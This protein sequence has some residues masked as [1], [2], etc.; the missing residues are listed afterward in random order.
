MQEAGQEGYAVRGWY[1][2]LL[3]AGVPG[4]I[5]QKLNQAARLALREP[6]VAARLASFGSPYVAGS[7]EDFA[8]LIA[9]DIA[10]WRDVAQRARIVIE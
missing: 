8:M 3:P 6:A 10:R 2:L 4:A 9:E 1:G 7:A 5:V